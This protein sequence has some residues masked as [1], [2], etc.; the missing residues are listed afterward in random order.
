MIA[1]LI[2]VTNRFTIISLIL[3]VNSEIITQYQY[4]IKAQ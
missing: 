3:T 1:L 2:T 4:N